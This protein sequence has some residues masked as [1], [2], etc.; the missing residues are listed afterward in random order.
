[1]A[2]GPGAAWPWGAASLLGAEAVWDEEWWLGA[3]LESR[4]DRDGAWAWGVAWKSERV[5]VWKSERVLVS[6]LAWAAWAL[7]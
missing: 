5:L 6:A 4:L 3:V 2:S 7:A 1:M